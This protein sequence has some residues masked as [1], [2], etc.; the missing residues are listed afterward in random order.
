[1]IRCNS[2]SAVQPWLGGAVQCVNMAVCSALQSEQSQ[3]EQWLL[4]IGEML[5]FADAD[6]T[7]FSISPAGQQHRAER[8][9]LQ[10]LHCQAAIS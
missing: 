2:C 1:M 4:H 3:A 9:A 10:S 8:P 6:R 5:C 7:N